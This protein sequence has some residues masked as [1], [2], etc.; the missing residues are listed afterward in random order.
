MRSILSIGALVLIAYFA[1]EHY[2]GTGGFPVFDGPE[3]EPVYGR[4]TATQTIGSR[5]I[6]GIVI[7]RNH[8][9]EEC[10]QRGSRAAQGLLVNCRDCDQAEVQ[11]LDNL[12]PRESGY[13][14]KRPTHLTY[15][16]GEPGKRDERAGAI[17]FWGLTV[18]EA[19][20]ACDMLKSKL[21]QQYSGPLTCVRERDA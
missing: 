7:I 4:M 21:A 19:R 9:R 11:C 8:S 13:F 18:D 10:E 12:S 1:Y 20:Q 16:V 3:G 6:E 15:L 14:E 2:S 17:I 5:E